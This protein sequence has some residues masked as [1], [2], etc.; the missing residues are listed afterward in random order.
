MI[1][2]PTA[3]K[4]GLQLLAVVK[5]CERKTSRD[6]RKRNFLSKMNFENINSLVRWYLWY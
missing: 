2:Q 1:L 3:H 5:Y 4:L 6:D